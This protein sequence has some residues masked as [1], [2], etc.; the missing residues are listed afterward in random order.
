MFQEIKEKFKE[1]SILVHFD[2]EKSAIIDADASEK[3]MR[4]QLQQLDN[5]E[6]KRLIT[7]YAQK[8]T[9]TK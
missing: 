1:E 4:A 8:L 3:V 5:Q 9:S 7:C 2:Y 6:Q